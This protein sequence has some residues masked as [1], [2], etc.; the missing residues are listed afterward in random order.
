MCPKCHERL[1]AG[2]GEISAS[3]ILANI[4]NCCSQAI[5]FINGESPILESVF[6][7]FLGNGNKPLDVEELG[8]QLSKH[9]GRDTYRTSAEILSRL[10]ESDQYYGLRQVPES[11]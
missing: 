8:K 3:D 7:F 4:K 1:K 2:E 9:C 6:R 5:D 11:G 10:L